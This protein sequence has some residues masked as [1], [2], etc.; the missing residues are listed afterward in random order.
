MHPAPDLH[1]SA[2][3][4]EHALGPV[5]PI[6]KIFYTAHT[7]RTKL[8]LAGRGMQSG[9][10]VGMAQGTQAAQAPKPA[11]RRTTRRNLWLA[12]IAGD[13]SRCVL[14]VAG[15][16][17]RRF[18][19]ISIVI[20]SLGLAGVA[21][22]AGISGGHAVVARAKVRDRHSLLNMV[23]A[24]YAATAPAPALPSPRL[25]RATSLPPRAQDAR[26]RHKRRFPIWAEGF[27]KP[28]EYDPAVGRLYSLLPPNGNYVAECTAT[29]VA[30]NVV[31][32][33]AHCVYDLQSGQ[34]AL[35]Y[36]FV[37]GMDGS[38]QPFGA[39]TG[40]AS[41]YWSQF[42]KAP[43]ASLDYA[44]V[45]L[46]PNR[47]GQNVGDVTGD[48]NIVEYARP[49]RV[50]AEGY[51]ASGP[52]SHSCTLTSCF[53]TYCLSP[54]GGIFR[55]AFGYV[56]GIGCVTAHG[57]SGGPWFVRFH[58]QW[59]IGSLTSIGFSLPHVR[60]TRVIFGPQFRSNLDVLLQAARSG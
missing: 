48:Y 33:A 36:V 40:T 23:R 38:S 58:G 56:L 50:I 49:H 39:W 10:G 2:D 30:V 11:K 51:P 15:T 60:Y 13:P 16:M 27:L 18:L 52:F 9:K 46:D 5:A 47:T 45:T 29:V 20:I 12:R 14:A 25:A 32:T 41:E 19:T 6:T 44:F 7:R 24:A 57:S 35:G 53:A 37:P 55:G 3:C 1:P 22:A 17:T 42:A 28:S 21:S 8:S 31:I 26:R 59:A 4:E 43:A 54:L 34:P